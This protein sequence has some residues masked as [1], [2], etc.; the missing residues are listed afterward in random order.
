MHRL[1]LS[2]ILV[3]TSAAPVAAQTPRVSAPITDVQYE[4]T[5][6]SAAVGR[7]QLGVSMTF[8]VNGTAPV[9]LALPAW[10]PGHYVLLWFARR[11][12]QFSPES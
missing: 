1:V 9:V 7:R 6:D 2:A 4:I 3:L 5:A 10:S 12:Q 11:V 8:H